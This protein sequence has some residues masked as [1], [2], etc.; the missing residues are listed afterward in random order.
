MKKILFFVSLML[1]PLAANAQIAKFKSVFTL[2]FIRHIGWPE[3]AKEGD[4]VIGVVK[5]K[6]IVSWLEKLSEGKKFG[7]QEVVIKEFKSIEE[8]QN[9]QV[10][11]V[12]SSI[13]FNRHASEIVSKVGGKNTLI[14]CESEGATDN[15]AMFNFVV[16]EER[17]KFE[18]HKA[19]AAK[20]GL[21]ISSKLEGMQ[22][23]IS[24]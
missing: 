12:S 17:L 7:F 4:F 18:I 10:L 21:Q 13:N 20:F 23:A 16:R 11:F 3:A 19:N 5:D 15:G 1:L 14:V 24:L 22:A 9:C 6:E 2:N 8:V